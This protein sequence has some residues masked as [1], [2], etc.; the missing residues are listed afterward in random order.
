MTETVTKEKRSEIMRKV[1]QKNT[2]PELFVRKLT[3]RLGYRYRL[4]RRDIP[5]TP[6]LAFIGRRKVIF[7]HGCFWHAHE[8]C[9][10]SRPPKSNTEFWLPKLAR[11]KAR[12]EATSKQLSEQGWDVLTI[13]ECE[14]KAPEKLEEK[15]S[16]FIEDRT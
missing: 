5:G 13:W 3:Y 11:N 9:K 15:I 16:R 10:Y 2:K 6:D 7:V 4:H 1:P 14:L 8:N 12:D